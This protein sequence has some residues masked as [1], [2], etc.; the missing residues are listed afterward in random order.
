M[1]I[2]T[3]RCSRKWAGRRGVSKP[4]IF[5]TPAFLRYASEHLILVEVDF[6]KRRKLSPA[7]KTQNDAL[8]RQYGIHQFPIV[9]VLD[10]EG[11]PLGMLGYTEGGPQAFVAELEKL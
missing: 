9:V 10:S 3:R 6:P 8:K 1:A 11:Q 4:E 2:P 5:S 7:L